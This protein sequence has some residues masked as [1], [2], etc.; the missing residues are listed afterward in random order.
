[1]LLRC[2]AVA[3]A[4]A[5]SR[6][7]PRL[8]EGPRRSS[9]SVTAE[10]VSSMGRRSGSTCSS[11]IMTEVST[12]PR[13]ARDS[14]TRRGVLTEV[15]VDIATE[16]FWRDGWSS[17]ECGDRRFSSH[18]LSAERLQLTDRHTVAC[19]D[20]TLAPIERSHDLAAFVTELPLRDM[21]CHALSVAPVLP[22]LPSVLAPPDEGRLGLRSTQPPSPRAADSDRIRPDD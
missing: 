4:A 3:P 13:R 10:I 22:R 21:P 17:P 16:A 2:V 6:A 15:A 12:K 5:P 11:S 1:V 18:E 19:D 14:R 8:R 7:R 9:A 20:E